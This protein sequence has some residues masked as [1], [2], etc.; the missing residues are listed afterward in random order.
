VRITTLCYIAAMA[1]D[2]FSR[3]DIEYHRATAA[4]YDEEVTGVFGIYHRYLLDPFL[5]RVAAK[6]GAAARALDLG[7]GTGAITVPLVE[8]GFDVLGIDHSAEMLEIAERKL[9]EATGRGTYRLI[10]GDVRALPVGDAE[11]D[12][13]TCQG[14]LHHLEDFDHCLRELVRVLRPGGFFYIGEPCVNVTPLKRGL[15]SAWHALLPPRERHAD[16]VPESIEAPIDAE[17][18]RLALE[19]FGLSFEMQFLTH[20]APL[21][22]QLSDRLYLQAVRVASLPW[23]RTR[24]DLVF[25]FGRKAGENG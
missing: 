13:V 18:L 23:R 19:K 3:R 21:R 8:R 12:C 1:K 5:D 25:V 20:L 2:D 6:T 7:C 16:D 11:F 24:G 10:T 4:S 17:A 15:A 9:A 14:L 22:S